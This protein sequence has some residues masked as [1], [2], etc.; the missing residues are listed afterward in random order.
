MGARVRSSSTDGAL[1]RSRADHDPVA[2]QIIGAILSVLV[3]G[4]GIGLIATGR[5]TA[6]LVA[7]LAPLA[8]LV[9]AFVYGEVKSRALANND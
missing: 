2:R 9:G 8:V 3:L 4:A 7:L 5:G 1:Y 6:G